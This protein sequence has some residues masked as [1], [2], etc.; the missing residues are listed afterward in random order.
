[1]KGAVGRGQHDL[2]VGVDVAQLAEEGVAM[3]GQSDVAEF[4][5]K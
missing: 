3:S 2:V 5:R 1:M 4:A